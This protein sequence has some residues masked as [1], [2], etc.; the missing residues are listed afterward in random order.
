MSKEKKSQK[1][2]FAEAFNELTKYNFN[3]TSILVRDIFECITKS[4][5]VLDGYLIRI[6]FDYIFIMNRSL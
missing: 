2:V 1:E 4:Y 6:Q 5:M 3:V